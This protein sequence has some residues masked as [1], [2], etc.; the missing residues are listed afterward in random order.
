ML[1]EDFPLSITKYPENI[2]I[3]YFY[4]IRNKNTGVK[5]VGVK[6]AQNANPNN[7]WKKYFTSSKVVAQIIEDNGPDIFEIIHVISQDDLGESVYDYET[8]FLLTYSCTKSSDWY[9]ISN[10]MG[11]LDVSSEEAKAS[12]RKTNTS[13]HGFP[14]ALQ[15]PELQ[16]KKM[17]TCRVLYGGNSPMCDLEVQEKSK[18]TNII[19]LGVPYPMQS[20][21]VLQKSVD[22]CTDVYGFPYAN[23]SPQVK[24]KIEETMKKNFKEG[25]NTRTPEGRKLLSKRSYDRWDNSTEIIQCPYCDVSSINNGTMVQHHFDRCKNNP[26]RVIVASPIITQEARDKMSK[27]SKL[28]WANKPLLKCPYCNKETKSESV[29][30]RWHGENCKSKV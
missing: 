12:L 24:A 11:D 28:A 2:R 3:P 6:W 21:E 20:P 16:K 5:Y 7:L 27:A 23:Q 1:F 9:N 8:D 4:I 30:S 26:N 19:R 14:V 13:R 17:A 15:N 29:F 25:H 22:T 10:N 18:A